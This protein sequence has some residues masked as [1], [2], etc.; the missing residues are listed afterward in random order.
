MVAESSTN[1]TNAPRHGRPDLPSARPVSRMMTVAGSDAGGRNL[2]N[3]AIPQVN[4]AKPAKRPL[5]VDS[6]NGNYGG[7]TAAN[8][9]ERESVATQK[10]RPGQTYQKLDAKRR[11]TNENNGLGSGDYSAVA[12][13]GKAYDEMD[14]DI[15][16]EVEGRDEGNR[17]SVMAPPIRHSNIRKVSCHLRCRCYKLPVAR[18]GL[19]APFP[20]DFFR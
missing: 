10:Q 16:N 15:E 6:N 20:H 12:G 9:A 17:R 2:S 3:M 13:V 1:A 14:D 18:N 5:Q 19:L 4:P 11:K 8:R 7:G